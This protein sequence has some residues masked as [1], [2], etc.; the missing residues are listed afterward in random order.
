MAAP[1]SAL[2]GSLRVPETATLYKAFTSVAERAA[3]IGEAGALLVGAT[4]AH[5]VTEAQHSLLRLTVH[6]PAEALSAIV[7]NL[8]APALGWGLLGDDATL[9]SRLLGTARVSLANTKAARVHHD[10]MVFYKRPKLRAGMTEAEQGALMNAAWATA[11]NAA[12]AANRGEAVTRS[13]HGAV[14]QPETAAHKLRV[15]SM[16][17]KS[18]AFRNTAADVA[19]R[20]RRWYG[21]TPTDRRV[22]AELISAHVF[23]TPFLEKVS[24]EHRAAK[25]AA[26]GLPAPNL[27]ITGD[28]AQ[29]IAGARRLMHEELTPEEL[30][31]GS[32]ARVAAGGGMIADPREARART[33]VRQSLRAL[34]VPEAG[35]EAM[36]TK[37][38]TR[39]I[40]MM[41]GGGRRTRRRRGTRRH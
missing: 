39:V 3:F 2:K 29:V 1:R 34:E 27:Q 5:F 9:W 35:L 37:I 18:A 22:A 8:T 4:E 41:V 38:M 23:P 26:A 28:L 31:A 19:A 6:A 16:T 20:Q 12:M 10:P 21:A 7:T 36:V 30:A 25:H 33:Y 14:N 17:A 24:R 40:A 13:A 32:A 15:G 11:V